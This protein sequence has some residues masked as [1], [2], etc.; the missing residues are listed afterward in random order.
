MANKTCMISRLNSKLGPAP[1]ASICLQ[2][3]VC[4]DFC[5]VAN[6]CLCLCTIKF[7]LVGI[8]LCINTAACCW[9]IMLSI[10][11]CCDVPVYLSWYL[12]NLLLLTTATVQTSL[13]KFGLIFI[14]HNIIPIPRIQYAESIRDCLDY[15]WIWEEIKDSAWML[16]KWSRRQWFHT[17]PKFRNEFYEGE[18]KTCHAFW[19]ICRQPTIDHQ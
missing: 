9:Y 10:Y 1:K 15:G 17:Q 18:V 14:L 3:E 2:V 11:M 19:I 4:F 7:P 13:I 8:L 6:G 12:P 16:Y 5:V